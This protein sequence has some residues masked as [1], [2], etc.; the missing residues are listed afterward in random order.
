M[1]VL[2]IVAWPY[3]TPKDL[4]DPAFYFSRSWRVYPFAV[5]LVSGVS[6]FARASET[7]QMTPVFISIVLSVAVSLGSIVSPRGKHF[8]AKQ[9]RHYQ[10]QERKGKA[11]NMSDDVR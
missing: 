7:G 2:I 5:G 3:R 11:K 9:M 6:G 10:K 8:I 4:D 1:I